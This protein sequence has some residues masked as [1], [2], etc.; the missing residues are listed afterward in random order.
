MDA[1]KTAVLIHGYHLGAESWE[2]LVWGNPDAGLY[3]SIP[4]GVTEAYREQAQL[5]FWGTGASERDGLKESEQIFKCAESHMN[6]LAAL[7]RCDE[8]TLRAFLAERSYIDTTTENT[9]GEITA[10]L[11]LCLQKE[12]ERVVIVSI[13]THASRSLKT[14][15][16]IIAAN[17]RFARYAGAVSFA[18]GNTSFA[19]STVDDVVVIEPPHRGDQTKWQTYRYVRAAFSVLKNGEDVFASFLADFGELLKKY[20]VSVDWDARR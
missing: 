17:Q 2:S 18:P 15:L 10:F 5:I 16:S 20:G 13:A 1:M 3:G 11:D 6:E 9:I 7:C 19:Q 8:S 4:R 12:I 14:A